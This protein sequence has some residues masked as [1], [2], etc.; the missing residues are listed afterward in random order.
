MKNLGSLAVLLTFAALPSAGARAQAKYIPIE[1]RKGYASIDQNDLRE[2]ITYLSSDRLAGRGSLQPGDDLATLWIAAQLAKAGADPAVTEPSGLPGYLQSFSVIEYQPDRANSTITLTRSGKGTVFHAPEAFGSYKHAVDISAP[3]VFAG[4]G[5]TAPELGYDDYNG[6][7]ATGKIVFVFDHEPQEDDPRSI[8]NGTGNTRYATMRVKLLNA[9]AHGAVALVIVAEPTRKHPTNL[10]RQMRIGGSLARTVPIPMQALETD[11]LTIPAITVDD[12]VAKDLLATSGT[13]GSD[14]QTGLDSTLQPHGMDLPDTSLKLHLVNSSERSGTIS[15]VAG[16]LRGYDP[17]LAGETVIISAHHDHEGAV[18]CPD[19]QGGVDERGQPTPPG[20]N[21]VQIWHG[22]DDNASG[23][24][25]VIELARAFAENR[26]RP[27]RSILF[28]VFAG[29][30]RGLLGSYWMVEHPLRPLGTTRAMINFDMIGRDEEPSPQTDGLIDIPADT[31]NRLNLMGAPY[32][33]DYDRIVRHENQLVDLQID[34]RFDH[35][36]VLNTL[37][38]SDQFPFLLHNVPACWWFTGF[39][40]DYHHITD[41]VEKIDF[42]KMQ[43]IL[44]LAYLVT[45]RFALDPTPPAFV[46]NPRP[47]LAGT[48]S[49]TPVLVETPHRGAAPSSASPE[50]DPAGIQTKSGSHD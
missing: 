34:D 11:A 15:N 27:R 7:D 10:E 45:W 29:E 17:T 13:T 46:T 42:P 40:P 43:K 50:S 41:T 14:L 1:M 3:V 49:S 8:F 2:K 35:E 26:D 20:P 33:P 25:G 38:R 48:P 16:I 28:V 37:F 9:Q 5:I 39:H 19:G 22:A 31:S 4:Y 36:H 6:I 23:T 12:D 47:P 30:E 32:S 44:Q 24:A 21:C 18:A